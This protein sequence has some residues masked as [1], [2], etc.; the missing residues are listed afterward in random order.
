[1]PEERALIQFR[2]IADDHQEPG[3]KSDTLTVHEGKWAFCPRDI[4]AKGHRWEA[5]GGV[6]LTDVRRIAERARMKERDR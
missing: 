4:R 6:T 3:S 1:M 5:T 2:C